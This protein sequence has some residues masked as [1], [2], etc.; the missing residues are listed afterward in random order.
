MSTPQWQYT[1]RRPKTDL[2]TAVSGIPN[3]RQLHGIVL[4]AAV[5]LA[6]VRA[7]ARCAVKPIASWQRSPSTIPVCQPIGMRCQSASFGLS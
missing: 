3:I 7:S 4:R 5:P 1:K 6:Q 2:R